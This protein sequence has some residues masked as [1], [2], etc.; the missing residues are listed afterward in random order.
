MQINKVAMIAL[1]LFY[2]ERSRIFF[3]LIFFRYSV[4]TGTSGN[5]TVT[6]FI[7]FSV[8]ISWL[9]MVSIRI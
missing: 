9:I 2:I 8:D 7:I 1:G 3:P 5:T 6:I 4:C